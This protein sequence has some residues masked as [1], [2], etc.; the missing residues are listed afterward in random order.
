MRA[1]LSWLRDYARLDAPVERLAEVLSEIG[2]VVEVVEHVGGGLDDVVV[3]EVLAI[4]P[5]PDADRI[6]LVDVDPGDGGPLQIV[7]G[8]WNFAEGDLVPL[9]PVGAVLPGDF[10][11]SRRKMRGEVSNGMLCSATEL[12]LPD[13]PG[14]EDGLLILEPGLAPPGTPIA[15][16]LGLRPDVVFDLDITANRPDA[17]C[18]AGIARDLAAAL[19]EDWAAPTDPPVPPVDPGLDPATVTVDAGDLCPRFTA[20]VITGGPRGPSTP[21]MGRRLTLAGMRPINAVVDVSNYVMLDVGQPNHAYDRDRLGGRGLLVRRG[22]E[23][24][25]LQTLDGVDRTVG[26]QDCVICDADGSPVGVGGVMGGAAAEIDDATQEVLLECAW[27]DPAA[28]ARTGNRIGLTSEARARFERGVDPAIA[29][30]AVDRFC[31]LLAAVPGGEGLRRGP[32]TDV[33]DPSL[34]GPARV[35]LRPS[36]VNSL[37]GVDLDAARVR[38]LLEPLGFV[39]HDAPDG[40]EVTVPTW[41][42]EVSREAD[43]I[44]EVARMWG[45]QR[46]ERT[47]PAGSRRRTGGL[48]PYQKERRRVR[49]ILAG[50]G[51]DEAWTT[52]FLAPGDLARAGL[53]PEA[54][55][56]E[57]PLDRSESLLRTSLLPGLLKALRFNVDRQLDDLAL[58]EIGRV[59]ARPAPDAAEARPVETEMLGI[60]LLPPPGTPETAAVESAVEAWKWLAGGLRIESPA[61]EA[62]VGPGLHPGRSARL[63]AGPRAVGRLGEVA[64]EVV[65]AYGLT[66]RLGWLE[67]DLGELHGAGRRSRVAV[68]AS[69]FPASDVDLAFVLPD[70]VPAAELVSAIRQA[71]GDLVEEVA[72]FDVYRGDRIGQGQRSLAVRAR[73]RAPHQTLTEAQLSATR[74]RMIEAGA[75][76]GGQLR[77]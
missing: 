30:V 41:R 25:H 4:R 46:I 36:R 49:A 7:C 73:L 23:G 3:A 28:V 51:L 22:R 50:A 26:P 72:L 33:A 58:F 42:L 52:T 59:F 34:P 64:P 8:A 37:L 17:L 1:P 60:A 16:A 70:A 77:T 21:E 40:F 39:L 54:V 10:T 19:G 45:Y 5:H 13:P 29:T 68:E 71:G 47:V 56:V 14:A 75:A 74:Q 35:R 32:T 57:N 63:L 9:A 38:G 62:A 31:A 20:T 61:L 67:V 53:D 48:T 2:L 44:E 6:R 27:F 18:M 76:A 43:L 55:E 11:I 12:G 24:E 69:R 65:S 66:G 15:A